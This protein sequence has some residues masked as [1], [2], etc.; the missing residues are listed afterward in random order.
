MGRFAGVGEE[1][2]GDMKCT[3]VTMSQNKD[4]I[5]MRSEAAVGVREDVVG[6]QAVAPNG[7]ERRFHREGML[8]VAVD[9]AVAMGSA[10]LVWAHLERA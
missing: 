4:T 1:E 8:S 6:V 10:L 2:A 5:A 9:K 3:M 7:S